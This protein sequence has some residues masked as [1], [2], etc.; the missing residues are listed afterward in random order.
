[1]EPVTLAVAIFSAV[2]GYALWAWQHRIRPWMAPLNAITSFKTWDRVPVPP[3]LASATS[4]S[5]IVPD[6]PP[7][8]ARLAEV[9]EALDSARR[10]LRNCEG[11]PELL[12]VGRKALESSSTLEEAVKALRLLLRDSGISDTLAQAIMLKKIDI[13]AF[14]PTLAEVIDYRIDSTKDNGCLVFEMPTS[15]IK[16]GRE[17][18]ETPVYQKVL[19]PFAK[20]VARAEKAKLVSV[21][22]QL[23]PILPQQISLSREIAKHA[24]I[25]ANANSRWLLR[26]LVSNF[27]SNPFIIFPEGANLLLRDPGITS[28]RLPCDL[29]VLDKDGDWVASTS[30]QVVVPGTTQS[31]G[32]ITTQ[33]Q[34]DM[35]QGHLVRAVFE[36]GTG[37][38]T[39][40]VAALGLA[41]MG[42]R[43]LRSRPV[44]FREQDEG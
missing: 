17:F 4:D 26:L 10:H 29:T 2:G 28:M 14:D 18:N 30:V 13:P 3:E 20:L 36:K 11:S 24:E 15:E 41:S 7:N 9:S 23:R 8:V 27:G 39:V 6:V 1:M 25:V 44:P 32:V 12:T 33:P 42:P 38:A 19:T 35:A 5:V 37:T 43:T 31:L 21:F 34:K 16:F 22:E 40:E